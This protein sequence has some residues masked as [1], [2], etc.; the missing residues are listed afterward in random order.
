M[1]KDV[2]I[3]CFHKWDTPQK[4][5]W[6][7]HDDRCCVEKKKPPG[8]PH[9]EVSPWAFVSL[10]LNA[11]FVAIIISSPLAFLYKLG[12]LP[13]SDYIDYQLYS[14]NYRNTSISLN[15]YY[16]TAFDDPI[17]CTMEQIQE[18][19]PKAVPTCPNKLELIDSENAPQLFVNLLLG[20]AILISY[21]FLIS[22]HDFCLLRNTLCY[23]DL[24][25]ILIFLVLTAS[26]YFWWFTDQC[27]N[28]KTS[29]LLQ[30][31]SPCDC[32]CRYELSPALKLGGLAYFFGTMRCLLQILSKSK[33]FFFFDVLYTG[34]FIP[35]DIARRLSPRNPFS[36]PRYWNTSTTSSL[37]YEAYP[38]G[39][40]MW[41][42]YVNS[43]IAVI[44]LEI[45]LFS[46][47]AIDIFF[48]VSIHRY[49]AQPASLLKIIV[50][51]SVLHSLT[52]TLHLQAR[53]CKELGRK[54]WCCLSYYGCC[55]CVLR[56]T[57]F[58][59]QSLC[60]IFR[61]CCGDSY[62]SFLK[63]DGFDYFPDYEENAWCFAVCC[64]GCCGHQN[65]SKTMGQC[66][67]EDAGFQS[68]N[69]HSFT[70]Q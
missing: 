47:L 56:C 60:N 39:V 54:C 24:H 29:Y 21:I 11:V 68:S 42:V 41:L 26:Q 52:W 55:H 5:I 30:V 17:R 1:S 53:G 61:R 13:H 14:P 66:F 46:L 16:S 10:V 65:Y 32:S 70:L 58:C 44:S 22:V 19:Y 33:L 38:P 2:T 48:D 63:T 7:L 23:R 15:L 12:R 50:I 62:N 43:A 49:V 37:R 31:N 20:V 25:W 36:L 34:P 27:L 9:A 64:C 18:C 4:I 35:Y 45:I 57:G 6:T 51:P 59:E 40:F 8:D 28:P 69:A 67:C 3:F